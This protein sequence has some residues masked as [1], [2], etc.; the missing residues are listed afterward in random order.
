MVLM[1]L[2]AHYR[3]AVDGALVG[4]GWGWAS[5]C[6]LLYCLPRLSL[7]ALL[8]YSGLSQLPLS[9]SATDT[10]ECDWSLA[11]ASQAFTVMRKVSTMS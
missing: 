11:L 4:F 7:M 8:V 3:S 5:W 9:S 10:F 1:V 6:W 2:F